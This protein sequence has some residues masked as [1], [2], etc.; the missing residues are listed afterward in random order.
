MRVAVFLCAA[1]AA[2]MVPAAV[3]ADDP[4]DP[5]MRS[6]A[7]RERDRAIIRQ[8]NRDELARVRRRDAGYAEGWRAA[9][10]GG[11]HAARSRDHQRALADYARKREQHEQDMAAWRR[12]V[13]AC[14]AGDY[15]AC[16]G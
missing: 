10:E 1:V 14:R 16:D 12:A 13:A 2:A 8:L 9:R 3:H 7:A 5:T 11:G 4:R 15:S 6:A